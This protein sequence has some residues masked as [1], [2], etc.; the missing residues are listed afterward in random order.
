MLLHNAQ[1]ERKPVPISFA[2]IC[3]MTFVVLFFSFALALA[4]A[5]ANDASPHPFA[6]PS[7]ES[8]A[9]A[10]TAQTTEPTAVSGP[11]GPVSALLYRAMRIQQDYFRG[12]AKAFRSFNL[13]GSLGAAATL[14]GLSFAYGIFHAVGPGHGKFIVTSYLMADER[15]VRRG[16]A[17]AF[18]SS[19]AQALTA[20]IVV[21]VLAI[22][23]GLTH[24]AVAD[25]IPTI[26]RAS[27]LLVI[28]V[29]LVLIWRALK[30][31]HHH[32]HSHG[33]DH[34]HDHHH[35]H[36]HAGHAHMPAPEAL[37]NVHSWRDMAGVILAVGLRPC[38]GAVLVLL[39]ALTQGA[40]LIGVLS[41]FA[42]SIGTAITVSLLAVL[43][44][45][46]KSV[47]LRLAGVADNLW[48]ARIERG[49][50]ITG[51]LLILLLGTIMLA[52]S[53]LMPAQPLL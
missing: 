12:L 45:A 2:S 8:G 21:G 37:R 11:T 15:D 43:T 36:D 41:A 17:L 48:A 22:I 49:L 39:F 44:L 34:G 35:E 51:G 50:K 14:I 38:T 46:S 13:E 53:L 3:H 6:M 19:T 26:E 4:P 18:L 20:I 23:L 30:G 52:S 25:A 27:F 24:R 9:A 32:D 47:A 10:D 7:N 40:F 42:M 1:N 28:A 29:G 5:H 33:H 16:I 31:D